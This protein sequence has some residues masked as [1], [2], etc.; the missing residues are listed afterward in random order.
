G[1][2][3][4]GA[5][6][7]GRAADPDRDADGVWAGG[8]RLALGR[9]GGVRLPGEAVPGAGPVAGDP[10][11]SGAPRGAGGAARG[12]GGV[13]R[14]ARG[15]EGGRAGGGDPAGGG[16]AERRGGHSTAAEG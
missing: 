12:G 14:G 7:P 5:A 13:G 2:D 9:G 16:G 15:P 6:D 11:G 3:R 1:R 10:D 4:G 8:A